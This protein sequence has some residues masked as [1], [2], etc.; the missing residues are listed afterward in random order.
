MGKI[1]ILSVTLVSSKI[2]GEKLFAFPYFI[3]Y[4]LFLSWQFKKV[5][6]SGQVKMRQLCV[7]GRWSFTILAHMQHFHSGLVSI[8]ARKVRKEG[9][10]SFKC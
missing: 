7:L 4:T 8:L 3:K 10:Y 6:E 9:C 2:I 5:F 1:E